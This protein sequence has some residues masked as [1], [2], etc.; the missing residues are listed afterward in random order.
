MSDDKII[1]RN[2]K[3]EYRYVLQQ[4]FEAGIVL[5]GAE[6]KSLRQGHVGFEDAHAVVRNGE[7][8]LKSLHIPPYA[9]TRAGS[10]NP[11]IE[12]KLLLKRSE[13]R[14]IQMRVEAKGMTIIPVSLYFK[15]GWA[16]VEIALALGKRQYDK[17]QAIKEREQKRELDRFKKIRKGLIGK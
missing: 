10:Y 8:Y 16:K 7:V 3:A 15:N 5:S 2:R 12:R 4:R 9:H 1:G 17:R 6:V 11:T 13:I 14:K